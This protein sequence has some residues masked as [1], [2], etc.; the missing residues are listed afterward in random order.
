MAGMA[1]R[2]YAATFEIRLKILLANANASGMGADAK[3]D[4]LGRRNE[5]VDSAAR[6]AKNLG[7]FIHGQQAWNGL[8]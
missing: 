4:N 8:S 5:R 7:D 2:L 1:G 6:A 3:A